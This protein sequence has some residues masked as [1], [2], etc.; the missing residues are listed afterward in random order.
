MNTRVS[1][2]AGTAN[3]MAPATAPT[4][5]RTRMARSFV[6]KFPG[7]G[8]YGAPVESWLST[9]VDAPVPRRDSIPR[10]PPRRQLRS[11]PAGDF[12]G[13]RGFSATLTRHG[14]DNR[15]EIIIVRR[16]ERP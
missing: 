11:R 10:F 6:A 5:S 13:G 8:S 15:A 1:V 16:H 12:V 4:K 9:S 2:W 7:R 14:L 3:V